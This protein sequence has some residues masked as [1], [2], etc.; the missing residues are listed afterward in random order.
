MNSQSARFDSWQTEYSWEHCKLNNGQYGQFLSSYLR[1]QKTPLVLNLDGSWG[2]GKT[3]F[4]RQL[5]SDLHFNHGFP[6][7]YIDAWESDYSNDPLLVIVSELLEQLKR[8]DQ[9]F[10][11]AD[12]EKK[13]LATL[14]KFGQKAWNTALIG[15]GTYLSGKVDNTAIV[16]FTKEFTFKNVDAAVIGTNLTNNYKLQKQALEDARKS[17]ETLVEFCPQ[18]RRKVFVLIDELDRCRPSYAIEMLETIKH[19]FELN[20][21]VFVVATDTTQLSHSINAVYGSKFDGQEYL[22]RFFSRS[23]KLP[24]PDLTLFCNLLVERMS[25]DNLTNV[26]CLTDGR[27][28]K[29]SLAETFR[30]LAQI[31]GCSLRRLDQIAAKFE[32]ITGYAAE[33]SPNLLLDANLLIQ[34]LIEFDSSKFRSL[35]DA[36]VATKKFAISIPP[37]LKSL[38]GNSGAN[39]IVHVSNIN[40]GADFGKTT[41]AQELFEQYQFSWDFSVFDRRPNIENN[42]P[43]EYLVIK[44]KESLSTNYQKLQ[45][46]YWTKIIEQCPRDGLVATPEKYYGFVELARHQS[47]L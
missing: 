30:E 13:I 25:D 7:I 41:R 35:Y 17:L 18:N 24:Q 4:L 46:Q 12:T 22:S 36:R 5:Y 11:A 9:H 32:S 33:S 8:A 45:E 14:G 21:Y 39:P 3:T 1:N 23:A 43:L 38:S 15:A 42:A 26:F 44:G 29:H 20:N 31:Y 37:N 6:C 40:L 10:K 47:T 28:L 34:L 27:D 16:E 2:T 19:F